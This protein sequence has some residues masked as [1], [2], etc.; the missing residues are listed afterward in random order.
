MHHG[1][2]QAWNAGHPPEGDGGAPAKPL[3]D[4]TPGPRPRKTAARTGPGRNRTNGRPDTKLRSNTSDLPAEGRGRGKLNHRR[5][6]M[7]TMLDHGQRPNRA[8]ENGSAP[9]VPAARTPRRHGASSPTR[10]SKTSTR[11][12]RSAATACSGESTGMRAPTSTTTPGSAPAR[13]PASKSPAPTEQQLDRPA[14]GK[15]E[16][17]WT[18]TNHRGNPASRRRRRPHPTTKGHGWTSRLEAA[19]VI[20]DRLIQGANSLRETVREGRKTP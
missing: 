17:I 20:L 13:A 15:R 16:E 12:A 11:S 5:K 19:A 14:D 4:A 10:S 1:V 9:G 3:H 7:V 6:Q 8:A 18:N 2:R